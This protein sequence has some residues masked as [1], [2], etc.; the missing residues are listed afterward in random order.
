ME[1]KLIKKKDKLKKIKKYETISFLIAITFFMIFCSLNV[2]N[3]KYSVLNS[4]IVVKTNDYK[5]ISYDTTNYVYLSDISYMDKSSVKNGESIR[6]DKNAGSNLISVNVSGV[7]KYYIKGISAWATSDL[8]YDLKSLRESGKDYSHF[9]AYI[10]VDATQTNTYYNNGVTF[11]IYTSSDGENYQEV[12]KTGT[13]KGWDDAKFVDI[14]IKDA[15]YLRLYAYENGNSWYSHWYDDAVYADAKLTT[16]DYEEEE[17]VSDIIKPI[18]Y[19]DKIIKGKVSGDKEIALLQR[20]FVNNVGYDILQAYANYSLEYRDIFRWIMNDKEVLEEYILGGKPDGNYGTSLTILNDLYKNYKK[21]LSDD[22]NGHLYL[23][24]MVSISLTHSAPVGLWAT[25]A[26]DDPLDTNASEAIDRYAIYKKMYQD[27]LLSNIFSDLS[28]EEMRFVMN[29]IIDDEEIMW[30]NNYATLNNSTNPYTYVEYR[31]GYNY[32]QDKYTISTNKN[33]YNNKIR[34]TANVPYNFLNVNQ[35]A[36]GKEHT[37]TYGILNRPKLW[38]VFEEGGVCGAISKVGSNIQG[39]Y[40][41]PSTVVSQPGH[42]AYIYMTYDAKGNKT[43]SLYN[44]VYGWGQ[45][46]KTEKLSVRMPNGWGTGDYSKGYAASYILLSQAVLNDYAKYVQ[47]EKKVMMARVYENDYLK[48][49]EYY[50]EALKIQNINFDAWLGLINTYLN[51]SKTTSLDLLKLVQRISTDLR[52]YPLPMYEAL[53]LI[54]PRLKSSDHAVYITLLNNALEKASEAT[55]ADVL[56]PGPTKQVANYLLQNNDT[57]V[58]TFSFD[59]ERA[60]EIVLDERYEGNGVVWEYSIDSRNWKRVEGMSVKLTEKELSKISDELD[61][62]VRIVGAMDTVYDIDITK[63]EIPPTLY[64]NDL[65]NRLIGVNGTMEW[66]FSDKEKWTSFATS[67]PDLKGD[68]TVYVRIGY[69][70]N[71]LPS[72]AISYKFTSKGENEENHYIPLSRISI[73][74]YSSDEKGHNNGIENLLDG[75]INTIWHTLWNGND[76]EKYVILELN[77]LTYLSA[78]EYVPRPDAGNGNIRNAKISVS[79]DAKDWTVVV[80]ST[81]WDNNANRK[82]VD[83]ATPTLGKYIK[84]EGIETVGSYM[85]GAM[86]N[87]FENTTLNKSLAPTGQIKYSTTVLTNKDV[88]ATLIVDDDVTITNNEGSKNYIFEENGE[89]TF[90]FERDGL[91]GEA[92]ARVDWINK[93]KPTAEIKYSIVKETNQNVVATLVNTNKKITVTNNNGSKSY[94]FKENGEFTFQYV[95]DYGNKGS[96]TA[97]VDWIDKTPPTG[98]VIYSTTDLTNK[99][100]IATLKTNE[101]VIFINDTKDTHTFTENGEFTFWYTDKADNIASTT[102]KVDWIDK[103]PPKVTLKYSTTEE[104]SKDVTVTLESSEKIIINNNGGKNTYTFKKNGEFTFEYQDAAGNKGTITAKVTWIKEDKQ[105]VLVEIN[106]STSKKTN[107]DVVATLVN[108]TNNIKITNNNGKNTYTFKENGEFTFEY[109]DLNSKKASITAKVD[110]IDKTLPK[111]TISY[112]EKSLTNANVIATLKANEDIVILNNDGKDTYIFKE[113]GEFT[114]EYQDLAGNKNKTKVKVDW[115]DKTPSTGTITYSTKEFTNQNVIATLKMSE[116]GKIINNNGKNTYTFKDNGTFEFIIQDLA[117][118]E[119]KIIAKVDWIDKVLPTVNL[120]YSTKNK[121]KNPVTVTLESSEKIIINNNGGKNVYTFKENGEFT[122]EYAD[123]VGNKG[124]ITAKVT[125]IVKENEKENEKEQVEETK[126]SEEKENNNQNL[127]V[128]PNPIIPGGDIPPKPS[129]SFGTVPKN[130]Y[131]E[132]NINEDKV[133]EENAKE[134]VESEV[135]E[136][137]ENKEE[138]KKED[139][140]PNTG[141]SVNEG[142]K[143][144]SSSKTITIMSIVLIALTITFVGVGVILRMKKPKL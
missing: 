98:T 2:F 8:Y 109:E 103:I 28:V 7:K 140:K 70:G 11:T 58:A 144:S 97:K 4:N 72:D 17:N 125:W 65:E 5:T 68:K 87:L 83:F 90:E 73:Y 71:S 137:Q 19:Y 129:T 60:G 66:R 135:E 15:N 48:Q 82:R 102:A 141:A 57:V 38:I 119:S 130:P 133:T 122:F 128:S 64:N 132:N 16:D 27:G 62:A 24:M 47:A 39:S 31:D 14:D 94:T 67:E 80:P 106:Y 23:K 44:D 126:P 99:D 37:I 52:Y 51:D 25:G 88:T 21:D 6:L 75:N 81:S 118:N 42:A 107:K 100:V 78:L 142:L 134:D 136:E 113:N 121:T 36:N 127:T 91:K 79:K 138:P 13:L 143:N 55:D 74:K 20:E 63:S 9:K 108:K 40:G 110:W 69:S 101:E 86:F 50:E 76:K 29:N 46:G 89:F 123:L 92:T 10:G 43:W 12:Y 59:G 111:G 77:R 105:D 104:T 115:I 22:V 35:D 34:T 116:K 131:I 124:Q 84:I 18:S 85:S 96:T 33:F 54:E 1:V 45:S 139:K 61:I 30:L 114:F 41:I 53:Q 95:D 3:L 49:K 112:S 26:P 32:Y 120:K 93:E 56:Q 117:G